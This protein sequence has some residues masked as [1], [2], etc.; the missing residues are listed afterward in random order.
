M[1]HQNRTRGA[2]TQIRILERAVQIASVEGLD[3]MS[4]ATLASA[5]NMSKS[6]LFAHFRSKEALQI[7]IVDE[8][9]R[10]FRDAVL[11]PADG[12][13]GF[14]R[15]S[16]IID[17]YITYAGGTLFQGG[18]F[19]A[20]AIHEFDG[21]PGAVRARLQ[22]FLTMWNGEIRAAVVAGQMSGEVG[23]DVDPDQVV[24]WT[25]GMGLS[26]NWNAQMG[27][28]AKTLEIARTAAE[29]FLN[30]VRRQHRAAA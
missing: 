5:T 15:L 16:T 11:A 21:R 24:F 8:A 29:T 10:M 17:Q 25:T 13:T 30:V 18:C 3:A 1:T 14:A 6:G 28:R 19:F 23:D 7:A 12:M 27:D 20:G 4:L 22:Q 2:E 9:E 26:I